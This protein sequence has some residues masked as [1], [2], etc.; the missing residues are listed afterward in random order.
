MKRHRRRHR[1]E[2]GEHYSQAAWIGSE[3]RA[4]EAGSRLD[5][6]KKPVFV[7]PLGATFPIG[8]YHRG[9]PIDVGKEGMA[10]AAVFHFCCQI[11][12]EA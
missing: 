8:Q 10:E 3:T 5:A 2:F 4:I 7:V 11:L 1:H 9:S 12:I 6:N